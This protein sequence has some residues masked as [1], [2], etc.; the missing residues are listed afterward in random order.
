[1][2]GFSRTLGQL[3][4]DVQTQIDQILSQLRRVQEEAEDMI[5]TLS[6]QVRAL[7]E[8]VDQKTEVN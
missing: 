8:K 6:E 4:G 7:A 2:N 5:R 3:D 1:M